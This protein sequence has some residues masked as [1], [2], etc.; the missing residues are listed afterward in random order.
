MRPHHASTK[1][2]IELRVSTHHP[3]FVTEQLGN[4]LHLLTPRMQAPTSRPLPRGIH[5]I[6]TSGTVHDVTS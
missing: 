6:Q 3:Y 2:R 4:A 1:T 5:F